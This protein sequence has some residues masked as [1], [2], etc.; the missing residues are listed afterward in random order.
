MLPLSEQTVPIGD[1]KWE[2]CYDEECIF[3]EKIIY[4]HN[5]IRQKTIKAKSIEKRNRICEI[6]RFEHFALKLEMIKS[7]NTASYHPSCLSKYENKLF[8]QDGQRSKK[9]GVNLLNDWVYRRN[10][11]EKASKKVM[12]FIEE[13]LINGKQI[14]ALSDIYNL[15]LSLFEEENTENRMNLKDVSSYQRHHLLKKVLETFP[16]LTKTIYKNRIHLHRKDL[17]LNEIYSSGFEHAGNSLSK[18]KLMAFNIRRRVMEMDKRQLPKNNIVLEHIFDGECSIPDELYILIKSL[19]SGPRTSKN[20]RKEIKIASICS[21]IIYSMTNGA[22]KPSTSLS[23]GLVTKS[24]TG[25]RQMVEILNRLGHCVSYTMVEELETEL[26]Y[27]SSAHEHI[28]PYGLVNENSDLRTHVA[29]DNFDKFVETSSGKDTLHD[30]VGIVYQNIE[31]AEKDLGACVT[32]T[33]NNTIEQGRRRRK[34]YSSFD[35]SIV[36]YVKGSQILPCL[37]GA[38]D[39]CPENLRTATDLND[40]WM[41]YHAINIDGANRWFAWNAD[42]VVDNNPMQKIGYLPNINMSPTSD[43][44]VLKTLDVA[45]A[46][47]EECHQKYIIVTYDLAI[48]CK[49]YRIQADWSPKFDQVFITLG[50]FHTELSFFK[51]YIS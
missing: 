50:S 16:I 36:T 30:T 25:S 7:S 19:L 42:R 4:R 24:I 3:C 6:L 12:E 43:A 40:I 37:S 20:E 51:V 14:L 26:A 34:F 17:N 15:Y 21:S 32:W 48:A 27:G 18:I 47:A 31:V 22:V 46:I 10:V 49:A 33:N 23:L 28:L 29:F 39:Q 44:V 45:L 35:N 1:D 13:N 41:L 5:G 11:H 8:F 38:Y 2:D 9:S